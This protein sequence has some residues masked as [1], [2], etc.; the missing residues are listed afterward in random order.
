MTIKSAA[1]F[2]SL[3]ESENPEEYGRAAQEDALLKVWEEVLSIRPD[4]AFWVAHNKTVPTEILII[5]AE[6]SDPKVRDMVARKR[7]IPETLQLKLAADID[8]SVRHALAFNAKVSKRVL[9]VLEEDA[10]EF[11]RE[12]AR[13]RLAAWT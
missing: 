9:R 4:M 8:S 10:E 6:D 1:E 2:I 7:K 12:A 11:V 5:L 3:R 13:G